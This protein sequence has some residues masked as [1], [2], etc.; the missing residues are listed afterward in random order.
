MGDL[1]LKSSAGKYRQLGSRHV[2]QVYNF[3]RKDYDAQERP[4][5][6]SHFEEWITGLEA[7]NDDQINDEATS[8]LA[9]KVLACMQTLWLT[10]QIVSR[11]IQHKALTLLE[12]TSM[13]HVACAIIA[14]AAWWPKPQDSSVPIMIMCSDE[15]VQELSPSLCLPIMDT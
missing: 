2:A 9:T 7:I 12:V 15:A 13:G 1:C 6:L 4:P 10:T 5:S 8:D 11:L 3:V 14:Y